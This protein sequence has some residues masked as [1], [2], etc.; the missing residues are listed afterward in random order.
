MEPGGVSG[1]GAERARVLTL[2]LFAA[3]IAIAAVNAVLCIWYKSLSTKWD[4]FA[5]WL[6][7]PIYM[8]LLFQLLGRLSPKLR[9]SPGQQFLLILATW[10]TTGNPFLTIGVAAAQSVFTPVTAIYSYIINGLY[11]PAYRKWCWDLTPSLIAPKDPVELEKIWRGL[12]PGE[13]INWAPW[14]A[15]I[16]FWSLQ[17]VTIA[18]MFIILAYVVVGPRT[19]EVERLIYPQTVPLTVLLTNSGTWIEAGGKAKSKLLDLADP[20][21]KT[22]WASFAIG[23]ALLGM[24]PIFIEIVPILPISGFSWDIIDLPFHQWFQT[25]TFLPGA[26]MNARVLM[27]AAV[28][29]VLL[30]YDVLITLVLGYLVLWVLYPTIGVRLGILE[31]SPGAP[32]GGYTYYGFR[33]PLPLT[34]FAVYGLMYGVALLTLWQARGT[35]RAMLRGEMAGGELPVRQLLYLFAGLFV[36]WLALWTAAGAHPLVMIFFFIL[37]TLWHIAVARCMAEIWYHVTGT[38]HRCY[39]VLAW[40]FGASIGAWSW[41]PSQA[42]QA[43]YLANMDIALN[44]IGRYYQWNIAYAAHTYKWARDLNVSVRD[45]LLV[46]IA[47]AVIVFPTAFTFGI[48]WY[49]HAG[50]YTKLQATYRGLVDDALRM[51]VRAFGMNP[52]TQMPFWYHGLLSVLGILT[53]FAIHF[54]RTRIAWFMINPVA[55]AY[56]SEPREWFSFIV[57][58]TVKYIATRIVG[59]KRFEEYAAYVAAGLCWGLGATWLIGAVYDL[60]TSVLPGSFA[61][62]VP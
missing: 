1:A 33:P 8:V 12:M 13:T 41:A 57:A 44:S 45:V 29:Y 11:N 39:Y 37:Y 42:N 3:V 15:P 52:L 51:G 30:P 26:Y 22:F 49:Y 43:L 31:Y 4:T 62:Y 48:W 14:I 46:L 28:V 50:G 5:A 61:L 25:H 27:S 56:L 58:L 59:A 21:I 19:V 2:P 10:W 53:V 18:L 17:L 20:R 36:V 32:E 40:P 38:A 35:I 16:A 7:N 55:L 34:A 23:F 60:S 9:L 54:L 47:M 24:I 6:L